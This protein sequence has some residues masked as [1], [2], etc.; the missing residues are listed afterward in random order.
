MQVAQNAQS[1]NGGGTGTVRVAVQ[2]ARGAR[3]M[4]ESAALCA[5]LG[6]HYDPEEYD[7]LVARYRRARGDAF[8]AKLMAGP[9]A[10]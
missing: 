5:L 3:A 8:F 9:A 1:G 6:V 7:A 2:E 10:A 4:L